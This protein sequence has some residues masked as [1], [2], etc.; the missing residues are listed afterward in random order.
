MDWSKNLI[1]ESEYKLSPF[2]SSFLSKIV[3]LCNSKIKQGLKL[4][5][6]VDIV[7][8]IHSLSSRENS[9]YFSKVQAWKFTYQRWKGL[10]SQHWAGDLC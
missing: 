5:T 7:E 8:S 2:F 1:Y 9:G 10:D 3:K 4:N 6:G